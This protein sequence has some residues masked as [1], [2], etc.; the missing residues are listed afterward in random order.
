MAKTGA[1]DMAVAVALRKPSNGRLKSVKVPVM[2][3]VSEVVRC[4]N[5][6]EEDVPARQSQISDP[7]NTLWRLQQFDHLYIQCF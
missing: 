2:E 7:E 6:K 1:S 5:V 4:H 3:L